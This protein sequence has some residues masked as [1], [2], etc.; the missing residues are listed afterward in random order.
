MVAAILGGCSYGHNYKRMDVGRVDWSINS[1][2]KVSTYIVG[3]VSGI[4]YR[5]DAEES[6]SLFMSSKGIPGAE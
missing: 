3:A 6:M 2:K 4:I 1:W 5:I